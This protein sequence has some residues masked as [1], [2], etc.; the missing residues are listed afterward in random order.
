MLK[1]S[2]CLYWIVFLA[3]LLGGWLAAIGTQRK[4][5]GTD[6]PRAGFGGIGGVVVLLMSDGYSG[7]CSALYQERATI[8]LVMV[9]RRVR[10]RRHDCPVV[11]TPQ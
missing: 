6:I 8:V 10:R 7:A 9:L 3:G 4:L 1:N 5:R 11:G 2:N